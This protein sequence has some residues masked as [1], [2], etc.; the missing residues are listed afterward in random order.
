[1]I[2]LRFV[3]SDGQILSINDSAWGL[4]GASG[5]EKP[6]LSVFTQRAAIG[7]GDI[8]TGSR[9]GARDINILLQAKSA[10][11]N[12][13]LRRTATSFFTLGRTYDVYV[14]RYGETRYAPACYLNDFEIP[15][16][17][18]TIPITMH[19]GLLCP[20]GY[21]L[22]ADSFSENI[23]G[24]VGRAGWPYMTQGSY[25]RLVG[26]YSF[27]ETVYLDNDGDTETYCKAVFTA[28]GD[29]TNPKL[30]AGD[31]FVRVIGSMSVGDVL[32]IDGRS[33]AVTLNGANISTQLDKAS[34]FDGITF[35]IGTNSVGF[36]ADIGS[37][38]LD[39]YIYYNKRYMGA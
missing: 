17:K 5:F 39:V 32:I 15:T 4:I 18:L 37:N 9:V 35:A 11:L 21:F 38:V 23:A 2:T 3:R 22:S 19:L 26:I 30:I 28:R 7:D 29:V 14:S 16:E 10:A 33:K 34:N 20:E 27:A 8:V 25:G 6:S 31:G 12:D 1:M 36:A 13:V 24:T